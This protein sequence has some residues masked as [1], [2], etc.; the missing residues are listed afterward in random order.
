MANVIK[1]RP[2]D[3]PYVR[4]RGRLSRQGVVKWSPCLRT[5]HEPTWVNAMHGAKQ[6][7]GAPA[8]MR[9]VAGVE[10]ARL[11]GVPQPHR[12]PAPDFPPET[13]TTERRI[14]LETPP[15]SEDATAVVTGNRADYWVTFE[16]A[17]GKVLTRAPVRIR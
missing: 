17:Q 10:A 13:P 11:G 5:F 1:S 3:A 4:V 12:P 15:P 2:F 9:V 6:P 16:D 7:P 14:A 8:S